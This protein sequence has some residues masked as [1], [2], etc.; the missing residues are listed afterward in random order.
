VKKSRTQR[1]R[2]PQ[3]RAFA[4]PRHG[5]ARKGAGRKP[6]S[7]KAGPSHNSRPP[8]SARHP[9][10][11][12]QRLCADL[13]TLRAAAEFELLCSAIADAAKHDGFRVTHFSVQ[14][15]HLHYICEAQDTRTLTSGMRSL[16][17]MIAR[18]LNRLWRRKGQVFAE[19]FHARALETPTEVRNALVYVL[20]NARKH[21]IFGD[22][23]DPFSSGP[24]FDGWNDA[25]TPAERRARDK[26]RCEPCKAPTS[27]P[28]TWLLRVGWRR[29]GLI[30]PRSIPGGALARR[31]QARADQAALDALQRKLAEAARGSRE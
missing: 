12:T 21:G 13:P 3:Q 2:K 29:Q 20:N 26:A 30:D 16:G 19:R 10:L 9:L 11:V 6:K 14:S 1:G 24:W 28:Q 5:G 4:F 15:N 25:W 31:A 7:V 23:A 18:R 8:T 27:T 22:G 17:V